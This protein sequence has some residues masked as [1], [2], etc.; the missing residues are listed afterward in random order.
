[1]ERYEKIRLI[2]VALNIRGAEFARLI[3][4]SAPNYSQIKAGKRPVGE[5]ILNKLYV[6]L[7]IRKEWFENWNGD[8]NDPVLEQTRFFVKNK[9]NQP[10]NIP[11]IPPVRPDVVYIP[12]VNQYAY[13]GYVDHYCDTG[14]MDQLPKVPFITDSEEGG[15]YLCLEVK[16]DGMN[17]GTEESY[18]EGDRLYCREI[19]TGLWAISKLHRR[20]WD[21]VIVHSE[22]IFVKRILDHNSEN[23][24][25]TLHSLNDMYP[26][27]VIDMVEVKQIFNVIESARPRRR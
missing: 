17:N 20:K 18:L 21:F 22:G 13:A 2:N 24:T 7:N 19:P 5:G 9:D 12:F 11:V 16:G 3:E 4:I 27:K 26:D 6:H 25:I 23:R 1:M 8:L 15:N 10:A 14:Y